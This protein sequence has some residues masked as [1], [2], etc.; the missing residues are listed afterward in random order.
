LR[1]LLIEDDE[2]ESGYTVEHAAD[3]RA[4]LFRATEG[5]HDAIIT[6]RMLPGLDGLSIVQLLRHRGVTCRCSS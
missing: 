3:G 1:L 5:G 2:R 4:G 6:D